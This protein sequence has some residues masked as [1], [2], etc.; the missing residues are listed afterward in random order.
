MLDYDGTL[1]PFT[2]H[3]DRA[4]PYPGVRQLLQQ[5]M[6]TGRTRVVIVSGRDVNEAAKLLDLDPSPEI[7]GLHGLQ[8]RTSNG[9]TWLCTLD[10]A[11]LDALVDAGNWLVYQNLRD[12]AELKTGSIAV[13][14]RGL[15]EHRAEEVR[16]R[17]LLGWQ[18]IAE[19]SGLEL[20]EFDG[21][22]EICS[23]EANKGEP[24]RF[25]LRESPDAPSAYLGDD[26]TDERAFL[27]IQGHGLS[28]LVRPKWRRTNAQLWLRPPDDLLSFLTQWLEAAEKQ[29]SPDGWTENAAVNP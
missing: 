23:L 27:A 20:L 21:G 19:H 3:R 29:D 28:V 16:A 24:V 6:Q 4:F 10:Q 15:N 5:I 13:H 12:S 26:A 2:T 25:L 22:V 18:P 14:W 11:K 7:W 8:R 17:V 1:A 9:I